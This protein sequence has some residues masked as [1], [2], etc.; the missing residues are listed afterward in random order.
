MQKREEV[1]LLRVAQE[2]AVSEE[3]I[4][5]FSRSNALT[6]RGLIANAIGASSKQRKKLHAECDALICANMERVGKKAA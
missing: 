5:F 6:A 3:D 2:G 4:F 1:A